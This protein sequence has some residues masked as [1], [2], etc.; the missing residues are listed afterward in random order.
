MHATPA[1]YAEPPS[2]PPALEDCYFYHCM[3]IPGHGTVPGEWDLRGRA[4]E[5]LG[6]IDVSGKRVLE[7]GTAS[8]FLCFE[9][10]QRGAEVVACDLS[11]AQSWDIV[12][13]AGRDVA[14]EISVYKAHLGRI[15]NGYW[16]AHHAFGSRANVVY[17]DVY[18]IPAAVGPVDVATFGSVLLHVRDPFLALSRALALT[19][20]TAV[21]TE[22]APRVAGGPPK[23]GRRRPWRR[24]RHEPPEPTGAREDDEEPLVE[25][26]PDA[27]SPKIEVWWSLGPAAVSRML[28]VLGFETKRVTRHTQLSYGGPMELFTVVARRVRGAARQVGT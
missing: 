3:D 17:S 16:L 1:H 5:Y 21:V 9:M 8:G 14:A 7:V 15:N 22:V 23:A 12:P 25:F 13:F 2:S 28:G 19:R 10:E 24:G 27:A 11:P 4:H 18:S 20:D 6:G 26:L